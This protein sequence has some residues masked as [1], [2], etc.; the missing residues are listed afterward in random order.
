MSLMS[1]FRR[2]QRHLLAGA[3]VL[4]M[5]A[6]GIFPALRR[7]SPEAGGAVGTIRGEPVTQ[8]E[9]EDAQMALQ[10]V[11]Q[12]QMTNPRMP[13]MLRAMGAGLQTQ[14]VYT[15]LADEF[16]RFVFREEQQPSAEAVWRYLVLLREAE[17]NGI[18][19]TIAEQQDILKGLIPSGPDGEFNQDA[20]RRF[21]AMYPFTDA[22]LTRWTKQLATV[23]KLISL[24]ASAV[25]TTRP[26]RWMAYAYSREQARIEYVEVNPEWFEGLLEVSEEELRAFYEEHKDA[27]PDPQNGVVGYMAPERV[28]LEYAVAELDAIALEIEVTDDEIEQHYEEH[29]DEKYVVEPEEEPNEEGEEGAS[30]E[31]ED[32]EKPETEY[33]PLDEVRDAIREELIDQKAREEAQRRVDAVLEDLRETGERFGSGPQPLAQMARRHGL[34]YRMAETDDG[35][36]LL[37]REDVE[38]LLPAG[39]EMARFAFEEER[40]LYFPTPIQNPDGPPLVSQ[41][42]EK[43]E[44]EE[45]SFEQVK[46]QVRADY[47]RRKTLDRAEIFADKLREEAEEIGLEDAVEALRK[48]LNDLLG[49]DEAATGE[50]QELLTVEESRTFSRVSTRVPGPD[51][52]VP[53]VVERAFE[54]N[55]DKLAVVREEA[56]VSRVYVIRT[57][58]REPASADSFAQTDRFL[59]FGDLYRKRRFVLDGWMEELLARAE[60]GE[61]ITD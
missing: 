3:A 43:Q 8:G 36:R 37:S 57:I 41:V 7:M 6:W 9:F 23:V 45:Q 25:I 49:R 35:G 59:R 31:G 5:I 18:Q 60:R 56:P 27:L 2:H 53:E 21:L 61:Q 10:M 33:Q 38:E 30:D 29:K 54:L 1:W 17:A 40:N 16:R 32:S 26:A 13:A 15:I 44:P 24:K 50:E 22:Q 55:D 28:K 58:E 11:A 14:G 48:R 4:L 12:F 47:V 46:E 42:L 20:Y 39:G 19:V 34:K 51:R 52:N